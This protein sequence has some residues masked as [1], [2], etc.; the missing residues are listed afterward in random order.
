MARVAIVKM[1]RLL[2][3]ARRVEMVIIEALKPRST[4]LMRCRTLF[5]MMGTLEYSEGGTHLAMP[6][7]RLR[8]GLIVIE[9]WFGGY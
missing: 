8:A 7:T 6:K 3:F 5:V 9:A 2:A 1:P 4:T